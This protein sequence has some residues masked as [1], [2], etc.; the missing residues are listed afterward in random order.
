MTAIASLSETKK[1]T[2]STLFPSCKV[3]RILPIKGNVFPLAILTVTSFPIGFILLH[4]QWV[5]S[6][7]LMKLE[8]AP[9]SRTV[10]KRRIVLLV[11]PMLV[12][13]LYNSFF[14]GYIYGTRIVVSFDSLQG[15][16]MYPIPSRQILIFLWWGGFEGYKG[17]SLRNS[18]FTI[19]HKFLTN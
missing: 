16:W 8:L 14:R 11:M 15:R 17:R 6:S 10:S 4:K 3:R 9:V 13:T 12:E 2:F 5:K 1:R 19:W 18:F 7:S